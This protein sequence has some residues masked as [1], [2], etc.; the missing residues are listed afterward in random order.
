[1]V[2]ARTAGSFCSRLSAAAWYPQP[3]ARCWNSCRPI[4]ELVLSL[5][6]SACCLSVVC[7]ALSWPASAV[8]PPVA[9]RLCALG[10]FPS[11]GGLG[12]GSRPGDGRDAQLPRQ[13]TCAR[14]RGVVGEPGAAVGAGYDVLTTRANDLSAYPRPLSAH[15]SIPGKDVPG[16]QQCTS[17]PAYDATNSHSNATGAVCVLTQGTSTCNSS[18]VQL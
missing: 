5:F 12:P 14:I 4:L 13:V 11:E 16:R 15:E 18:G 1:M 3:K 8:R 7:I 10:H 2:G 9:T 17:V 6:R